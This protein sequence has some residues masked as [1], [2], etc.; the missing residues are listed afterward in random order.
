M[1]GKQTYC[2]L[3]KEVEGEMQPA[4]MHDAVGEEPP[5]LPPPVGPVHQGGVHGHGA[6]RRG[7]AAGP[8][9]VPSK[10]AQLQK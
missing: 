5:E 7:H 10:H 8:P 2:E 1:W 3:N 4:G 9:R 6:R